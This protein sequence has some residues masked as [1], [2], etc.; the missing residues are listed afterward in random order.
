[1]PQ[2]RLPDINTQYIKYTNE[3]ISSWKGKSYDSAIGSLNALNGLMPEEYRISI[4]TPEY[5]A[6]TYFDIKAECKHCKEEI[7]RHTIEP[8][9]LVNSFLTRLIS[10]S[11]TDKVWIC[12]K[13]KA[14][15]R[16]LDT[17]MTKPKL[18]EPYFIKVVPQ[19]PQ[20]KDGLLDRTRFHNK[21]SVWFWT[22]LGEISAEMAR[23]RDDNWT[24][25]DDLSEFDIPTEDTGEDKE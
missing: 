3:A 20:R 15:N 6:Q 22:C 23:F 2:A 11:N 8:F 7:E 21:F 24:K 16:L 25:G 1:M 9:D 5:E 14:T 17:T 10:G 19:P 4:N 13:C 18:K 12:P